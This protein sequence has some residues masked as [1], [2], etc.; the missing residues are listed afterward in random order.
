MISL[1]RQQKRRLSRVWSKNKWFVKDWKPMV[2]IR[3]ESDPVNNSRNVAI[4][5][6]NIYLCLVREY[7]EITHLSIKRYDKAPIHNWQHLQQ[8]KNDI[9]GEEREGMEIY[10]AMSRI[11]D[12]CNQYHLW[13]LRKGYRVIQ[14]YNCRS[15]S[16]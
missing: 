13:V 4:Y 14:G 15:V 6:N 11:V 3:N 12:T 16:I 8:L 7:Y 5:Q 10:P 1:T 2:F 9:C